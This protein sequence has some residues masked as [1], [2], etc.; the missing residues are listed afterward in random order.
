MTPQT[1]AAEKTMTVKATW[2]KGPSGPKKEAA[3]K[4]DQTG[5][6]PCSKA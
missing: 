5:K 3:L 6:A 1:N 4:H 2:D